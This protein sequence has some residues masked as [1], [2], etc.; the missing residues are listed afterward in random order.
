MLCKLA[1]LQEQQRVQ[2]AIVNL[3]RKQAG[4]EGKLGQFLR[5]LDRCVYEEKPME[6]LGG[7]VISRAMLSACL[8]EIRQICD[9]PIR[10]EELVPNNKRS[11]LEEALGKF[12][13]QEARETATTSFLLLYMRANQGVLTLAKVGVTHGNVYY[14]FV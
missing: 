1:L 13:S 8:S 11:P 2:M 10:P 14:I 12:V 3:L 4:D 7:V 9:F 5:D 6:K